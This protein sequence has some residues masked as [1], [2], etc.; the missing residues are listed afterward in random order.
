MS[1]TSKV[2]VAEAERAMRDGVI[3][4]Y[5]DNEDGTATIKDRMDRPGQGSWGTGSKEQTR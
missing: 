3:S 4:N 2:P 1:D 5:V